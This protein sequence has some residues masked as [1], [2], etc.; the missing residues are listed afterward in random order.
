M[1]ETHSDHIYNGI[2]KSIRLDQIDTEKVSIY[3]FKQDEK[4][5][6]I[7][8]NIPINEEGKALRNT[9]GFFDQINK[10]LDVILGW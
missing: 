2:R 10:D 3:S 4:G 7:P 5:C 8:I 9:D 1:I 6:S